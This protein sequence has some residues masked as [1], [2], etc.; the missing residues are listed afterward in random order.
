MDTQ[1]AVYC[2]QL[3]SMDWKIRKAKL[4][5]KAPT[6]ILDDALARIDAILN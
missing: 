5:E 3:K 6:Y 2:H 4:K 1:G